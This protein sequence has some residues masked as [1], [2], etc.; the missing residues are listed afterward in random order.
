L[1]FSTIHSH[2]QLYR[3]IGMEFILITYEHYVYYSL[4]IHVHYFLICTLWY[5]DFHE[6]T[7]ISFDIIL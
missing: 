1:L 6:F 4:I 2:F 3:R 5:D 7:V